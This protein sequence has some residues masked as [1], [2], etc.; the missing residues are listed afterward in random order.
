MTLH[1]TPFCSE[2]PSP[3]ATGEP[4]LTGSRIAARLAGLTPKQWRVLEL[5][6]LGRA[7]KQIAFE[8]GLGESTVKAH[9]SHI[10]EKLAVHSRT[11]A[12]IAVA[13]VDLARASRSAPCGPLPVAPQPQTEKTRPGR[14]LEDRLASLTPRQAKVLRLVCEGRFNK[15]IAFELAISEAT[16]KAHVS[17]VLRKLRVHSRTQAV[18]EMAAQRTLRPSASIDTATEQCLAR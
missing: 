11:Q 15:E 13:T 8:L 3:A 6:Q 7:N 14:S 12:A 17:A 9:V 2:A 10:L 16:V 18:R 4:A 1:Q 5:L